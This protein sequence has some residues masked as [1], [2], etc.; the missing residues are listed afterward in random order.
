MILYYLGDNA[1]IEKLE[2]TEQRPLNPETQLNVWLQRL[3]QRDYQTL[4][5]AYVGLQPM[6]QGGYEP[7]PQQD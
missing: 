7:N 4:R 5:Y 1:L 6:V 2:Q 3:A